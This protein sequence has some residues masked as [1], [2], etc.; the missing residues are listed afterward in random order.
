MQC[1]GEKT[2]KNLGVKFSLV[3]SLVND[4]LEAGTEKQKP[5]LQ[6]G[7][8]LIFWFDGLKRKKK[9]NKM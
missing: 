4:L 8:Y 5:L 2:I 9:K 3:R 6:L 7:K 1:P